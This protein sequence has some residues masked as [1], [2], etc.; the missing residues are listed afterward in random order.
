MDE[1]VVQFRVG[2]MVFATIIITAI[3]V[4]MF[5]R[6]PAWVFQPT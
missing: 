6:G 5:G 2:V 4:V 1:R 3:L